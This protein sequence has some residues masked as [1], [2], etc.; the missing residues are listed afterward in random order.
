MAKAK[1]GSPVPFRALLRFWLAV[2]GE[3]WHWTWSHPV[4]A[5][6]A[7]IVPPLITLPTLLAYAKVTTIQEAKAEIGPAIL[8]IG[9][10]VILW[11]LMFVIGVVRSAASIHAASVHRIS[12]L[13]GARTPLQ[14]IHDDS[15]HRFAAQNGQFCMFRVAVVNTGSATVKNVTLKITEFQGRTKRL[16]DGVQQFIRLPLAISEDP[17]GPAHAFRVKPQTSS[18][19]HQEDSVIFDFVQLCK[20]PKGKSCNF[21]I[22]HGQCFIDRQHTSDGRELTRVVSQPPN[23]FPSGK[24]EVTLSA[25]GD[26]LPPVTAKFE[27]WTTS[28]AIIFRQRSQTE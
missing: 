20:V 23:S 25:A 21:S 11:I 15:L 13:E 24:Y 6:G 16:T 17:T 14:I 18:L 5:G 4:I 2:T 28:R 19:L 27:F 10:G 9:V 12:E 26:D 1:A 3:A 8:A 22:W 7:L